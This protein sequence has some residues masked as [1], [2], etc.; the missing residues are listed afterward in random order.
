MIRS[1]QSSKDSRQRKRS[2]PLN[3]PEVN[4]NKVAE[5]KK[6]TRQARK[7]S[8][9]ARQPRRRV[10]T[11][12]P[13]K[14]EVSEE[15][16]NKEPINENDNSVQTEQPKI[17]KQQAE[18][19]TTLSTHSKAVEDEQFAAWK[20]ACPLSHVKL[21]SKLSKLSINDE[22]HDLDD[23]IAFNQEV[24]QMFSEEDRGDLVPSVLRECEC[25]AAIPTSTPDTPEIEPEPAK[26]AEVIKDPVVDSVED[27]EFSMI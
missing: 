17:I 25:A 11:P 27:E 16:S 5:Q 10:D 20:R 12:K 4:D 3:K 8:G 15:V 26:V 22:F 14:S 19:T 1:V 7:P 9:P 2:A 24:M 23:D 18:K 6:T 21:N 13:V